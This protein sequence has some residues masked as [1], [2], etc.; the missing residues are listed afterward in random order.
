MSESDGPSPISPLKSG[1]LHLH[2]PVPFIALMLVKTRIQLL[3]IDDF[4]GQGGFFIL[5]V[6]MMPFVCLFY[7]L[8]THFSMLSS[9]SIKFLFTST[10]TWGYRIQIS[11]RI[12]MTIYV[13]CHVNVGNRTLNFSVERTK[14]LPS[15][16]LLLACQKKVSWHFFFSFWYP[17][18]LL[19]SWFS[20]HCT[21]KL[22]QEINSF[23]GCHKEGKSDMK[24]LFGMPRVGYSTVRHKQDLIYMNI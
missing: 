11:Q 24:L 18:K 10:N 22:N 13:W 15:T 21:Y 16:N 8:K 20:L 23:G 9:S 17:P 7:S 12:H 5:Y 1:Q 4:G 6:C 3:Q 19:I 2:Y 14:P